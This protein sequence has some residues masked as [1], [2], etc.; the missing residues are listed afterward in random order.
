MYPNCPI[1][2]SINCM[3]AREGC[4]W[5]VDKGNISEKQNELDFSNAS[6]FVLNIC[7]LPLVLGFVAQLRAASLY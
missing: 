4:G 1:N 2:G 5:L 6:H 3:M 7:H